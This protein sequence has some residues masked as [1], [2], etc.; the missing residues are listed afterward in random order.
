LKPSSY[1]V[2]VEQ[3]GFAAIEYTDMPLAVGQ[4]LPLDFQIKPAGVQEDVTV[5]G[6]APVLDLSSARLGEPNK[7]QPGQPFTAASAGST[8]GRLNSTVGTT[9]GLGTNRQVQFA[10]RLNF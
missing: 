5:V 8:F 1:T 7:I 4:E 2:K 3:P 10:V 6:S 9:V